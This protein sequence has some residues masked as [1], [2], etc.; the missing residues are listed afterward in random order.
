MN[1]PSKEACEWAA[2]ALDELALRPGQWSV[3]P[4]GETPEDILIREFCE[5]I[6]A[7]GSKR[8]AE[9]A[10]YLRSLH[11]DSLGCCIIGMPGGVIPL[12]VH[13]RWNGMTGICALGHDTN[14]T[15]RD[16][17]E[18]RETIGDNHKCQCESCR[19][20]R[21]EATDGV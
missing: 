7:D 17:C 21:R 18:H 6:L 11:A 5:D 20:A 2:N 10:T 12:C 16:G 8:F 19:E 3:L 15:A 9:V 4:S 1:K 14:W 13:H